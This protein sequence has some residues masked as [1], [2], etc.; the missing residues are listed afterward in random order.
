MQLRASVKVN[1]P[2]HPR[3][4]QAG[5]VELLDDAETPTEALVRFDLD[6]A[7]EEV[8]LADLVLLGPN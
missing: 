3:H 6:K 4:E 8:G 2:E 1:N 7:A 5:V